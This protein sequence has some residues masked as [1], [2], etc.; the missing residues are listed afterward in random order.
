[1]KKIV[2]F[3]LALISLIGAFFVFNNYIYNEKQS[4]EDK[5]LPQTQ[6]LYESE[7]MGVSFEYQSGSEGYTLIEPENMRNESEEFVDGVVL[8]RTKDYE[9]MLSGPDRG[10]PPSINIRAFGAP[11]TELISWLQENTHFTNYQ[12]GR[13]EP[14]V[15]GGVEG[16]RYAWEGMFYGETIAVPYRGR[17]YMFDVTTFSEIEDPI[18]TDFNDI[19][20]TVSFT[21]PEQLTLTGTYDCL[22]ENAVI[23]PPS[24]DCTK[25]L[26]TS[27]GLI[28]ALDFMLMSQTLPALKTGDAITVSGVFTP[29]ERLSAIMW[30]ELDVE[31]IISATT[32]IK[33]VE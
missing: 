30:T 29:A 3:A 8:I 15:V 13:E 21:P 2:F 16:F 14:I 6:T 22:D 31:G 10:G 24:E 26:R 28:Y 7:T 18:M 23:N 25:G 4:D 17:I 9:D 27:E 11:D 1:M 20:E 19:L 32:L 33:E 12:S 5:V